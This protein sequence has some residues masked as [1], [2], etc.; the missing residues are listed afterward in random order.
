MM[1]THSKGESP[2]ELSGEFYCPLVKKEITARLVT[3]MV[4]NDEHIFE[5]HTP[6]P[7]GKEG[8]MMRIT[9]HRKK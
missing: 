3:K 2:D 4:S 5:M 9:Y 1:V 7:D 6:G 8:L